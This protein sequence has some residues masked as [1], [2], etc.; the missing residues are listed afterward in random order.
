MAELILDG[1]EIGA[2]GVRQAG[3]AEVGLRA[4]LGGEV[5]HGELPQAQEE[6]V[7]AVVRSALKVLAS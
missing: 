4:L 6:S 7:E 5:Q 2:R 3:L 1:L